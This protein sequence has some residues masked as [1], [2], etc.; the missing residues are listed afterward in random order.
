VA[1]VAHA[2]VDPANKAVAAN[3]MQWNA[4]RCGVAG[5][6]SPEESRLWWFSTGT[7]PFAAS[8]RYWRTA[9]LT[10]R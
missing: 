8:T 10:I 7:E 5:T 6:V 3:R 2:D 4:E 9:F 1:G